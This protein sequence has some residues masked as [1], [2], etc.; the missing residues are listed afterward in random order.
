M[1]EL[2]LL[3]NE[4]D[5]ELVPFLRQT[6]HSNKELGVDS[7]N[8]FRLRMP[9]F[10]EKWI[11][12]LGLVEATTRADLFHATDFYLPLRPNSPAI[13]NVYDVI[14]ATE[15]E[16]TVDHQ[17]L[18]TE[19]AR[20]A[21]QCIKVITC[22]EYS[23]REFCK[24]YGYPRERVTVIP[25]GIDN[26]HFRPG[27]SD[28]A[29][30]GYFLTVSCNER[31]KNTPRLIRAF[32]NY[33]KAGGRSD[34]KLAWSLP[35]NLAN[36]VQAAGM[37]NRIIP[38]DKVS[39]DEL[40]RLYQGA[41]CVMF[42]SLYEGFGFPVLESL[43]CGV[44]VL[45]T[46]RSSLPEVG[47]ELAIYVDGEDEEEITRQ[48]LAFDSGMYTQLSARIRREGPF[49]A[50]RFNWRKYAKDTVAVYQSSLDE[51]STRAWQPLQLRI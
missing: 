50:S 48:M 20:R 34:L 27:L 16:G 7:L 9:R 12:R 4:Q 43:A 21:G 22:S 32:I 49:W 25:L 35:D 2:P 51:L 5:I 39:E 10:S 3:C 26:S 6:L 44:P 18:A 47:G 19:M 41:R 8:P 31:R 14:Y 29:S 30:P 28:P 11:S 36:Q 1:R 23:A 33:A 45:T 40:L 38:I 46:R 24:L 17:R 13:A 15:S 37:S 42:P